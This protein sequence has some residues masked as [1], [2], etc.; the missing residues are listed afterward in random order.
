[1]LNAVMFDRMTFI[2]GGRA[3]MWVSTDQDGPMYEMLTML[4]YLQWLQVR[5]GRAEYATLLLLS[6]VTM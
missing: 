3:C 4:C 1:M 6:V 5:A 2:G